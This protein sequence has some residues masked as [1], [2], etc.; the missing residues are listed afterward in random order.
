MLSANE[1]SVGDIDIG[2][3][4]LIEQQ[5]HLG[6]VV[7]NVRSAQEEA[8]MSEVSA[9]VYP[10][11]VVTAVTSRYSDAYIVARAIDGFGAAIKG[12]GILIGALLAF[13][14]LA[15]ASKG[16]HGDVHCL[17]RYRG[18]R[19]IGT[20]VYLLGTLASAQG[21]ILK[22]TL[23]TAVNSSR[24]LSDRDRAQIMSLPFGTPVAPATALLSSV[25]QSEWR[26]RCGQ[27][28]ASGDSA[29]L[30]CGVRYGTA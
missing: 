24:F 3:R 29:C 16:G 12:I 18:S 1:S 21:Q 22:A 2:Q 13:V 8:A 6:A 23:D 19:H 4:E 30:E 20:V 14:S 27:K 26:C 28:N 9:Q 25:P 15:A 11:T 17:C 7:P 5:R 10:S